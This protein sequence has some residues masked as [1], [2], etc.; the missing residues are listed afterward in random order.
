MGLKNLYPATLIIFDIKNPR[1]AGYEGGCFFRY[2]TKFAPCKLLPLHCL[3]RS[4]K[5]RE[6]ATALQTCIDL[7]KGAIHFFQI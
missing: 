5:F 6:T 4:S 3:C 2:D 1:R 7:N